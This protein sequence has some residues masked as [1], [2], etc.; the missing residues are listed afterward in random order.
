MTATRDFEANEEIRFAI[1]PPQGVGGWS[2]GKLQKVDKNADK[3][4]VELIVPV[5]TKP[6]EYTAK[7]RGTYRFNNRSVNQEV[8]LPIAVKAAPTEP[9]K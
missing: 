4:V 1:L 2:L 8:I 9:E 5:N 3:G 7:L 6:G